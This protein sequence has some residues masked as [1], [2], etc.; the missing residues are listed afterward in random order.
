[1]PDLAASSPIESQQN[2]RATCSSMTVLTD[3]ENN[4]YAAANPLIAL[5]PDTGFVIQS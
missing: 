4:L 5:G 3:A 1:M 2:T